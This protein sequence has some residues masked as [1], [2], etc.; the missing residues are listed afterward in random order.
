MP[1]KN[2]T[3][4]TLS[5]KSPI[6]DVVLMTEDMQSLLRSGFSSFQSRGP[7]SRNKKRTRKNIKLY[8]RQSRRRDKNIFF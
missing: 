4:R 6:E 2:K 1:K 3:V 8:N 5:Y 7:K